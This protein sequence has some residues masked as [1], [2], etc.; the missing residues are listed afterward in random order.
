LGLT[1]GCA[2]CHDHKFD[3]ITQRDYYSLQAYLS[4]TSE[5]NEIIGSSSDRRTWEAATGQINRHVKKLEK[6]VDEAEGAERVRLKKQIS[7]LK[8]QLPPHLPTITT[9]RNDASKRTP[10][11]ILK[12]GL[13][14]QKGDLVGMRPLGVLVAAHVE[15]LPQDTSTPRTRL[16]NWL[17]SPQNPLTA[18]VIVNRIWQGHFGVGLVKSAN[19]FGNN[20]ERPSHPELLDFLAVQFMENGWRMKP[21][22]RLIVSSR[23]YRQTSA[24]RLSK[25]TQRIDPENRL[26][27]RF[28]RRRL[29][30]E[31][32][33]DAMLSVSG[34][35]NRKMHGESVMLPVDQPLIDLL[36]K[37]DQ[38]KLTTDREEHYRRSIYLI[39]KRNLRMPFMEV[40]DQPT[41]LSS[42]ALRESSTHA[43]QALELLNGRISNELAGFFAE[44]LRADA[45]ADPSAQIRL[46]F[47]LTT[48]MSPTAK[49]M[50]IASE[51]L[52]TEPLRE[53]ALSMLNINSFLYSQ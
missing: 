39:A 12:R 6:L 24:T 16:A 3:P 8:K 26:L 13:W 37:P 45:G 19:D 46:A 53:F 36:Y 20:G 21:L 28:N 34:R 32:I 25:V 29:S 23:T 17:T 50:R 7:E 48:G 4:S 27:W 18:R 31:E 47:R 5:H 41:A 42:C 51:F 2:R 35:L 38:W 14:E 49:E 52:E 30:A 11:H 15:Q 43:P 1:I 40:F 10:I 44:R 9:I 22:H 33:R